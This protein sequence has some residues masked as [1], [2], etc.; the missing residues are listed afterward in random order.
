VA[1]DLDRRCI[2]IEIDKDYVALA[3]KRLKAALVGSV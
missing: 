2:G 1:R 3:K